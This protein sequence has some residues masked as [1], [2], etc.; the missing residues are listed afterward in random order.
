M[1]SAVSLEYLIQSLNSL[2]Y[3]GVFV[4][5]TVLIAAHPT[6]L[7]ADYAYINGTNSFWYWNSKMII[8]AWVNQVICEAD[9]EL[10][11]KVQKSAVPYIILE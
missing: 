1:S 10:L 9:Y 6:G 5:T 4:S 7:I 2:P 8:P 3:K 11:T